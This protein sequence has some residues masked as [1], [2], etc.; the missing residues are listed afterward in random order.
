[1]KVEAKTSLISLS[2]VKK[3]DQH[4]A[5]YKRL[6][7][8]TKTNAQELLIKDLR[9]KESKAQEQE[10]KSAASQPI[11]EASHKARR[12]QRKDCRNRNKEQKA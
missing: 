2:I 7:E 6:A 3:L 5:H 11:A 1:M 4:V 10:A 9:S 8:S 12:D